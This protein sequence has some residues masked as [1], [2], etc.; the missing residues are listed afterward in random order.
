MSFLFLGFRGEASK[1]EF[2]RRVRA[3]RT[4]RHISNFAGWYGLQ[5]GMVVS[6]DYQAL[7]PFQRQI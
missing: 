1:Y 7:R 5:I 3:A 4:F 6:K 2:V